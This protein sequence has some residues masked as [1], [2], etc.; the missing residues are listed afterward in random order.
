[1]AEQTFRKSGQPRRAEAIDDLPGVSQ[2]RDLFDNLRTREMM[3]G[4]FADKEN[5]DWPL[6]VSALPHHGVNRGKK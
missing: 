5:V 4:I 3:T 6:A 1:M 2:T